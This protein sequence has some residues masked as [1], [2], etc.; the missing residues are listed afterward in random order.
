[1][2][3]PIINTVYQDIGHSVIVMGTY[4][5]VKVL[6][7]EKVVGVPLILEIEKPKKKE[8]QNLSFLMIKVERKD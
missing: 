4:W 6:K 2:G 1:M 7:F 3:S 8:R 5:D